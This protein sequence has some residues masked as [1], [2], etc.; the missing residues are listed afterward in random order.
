MPSKDEFFVHPLARGERGARA[1]AGGRGRVRVTQWVIETHFGTWNSAVSAAGLEPHRDNQRLDDAALLGEWGRVVRAVGRVPPRTAYRLA[2]GKYCD[3]LQHRFGGWRGVGRAFAMF[4]GELAEWGDVLAIVERDCSARSE[5]RAPRG[6]ARGSAIERKGVSF[7][8]AD[9]ATLGGPL[10]FEAMRHEPVN[11]QGVVLLFGMLA[12]RL[13]YLIETVQ[14]AFPDCEAKRRVGGGRW[15][16]VRIEFEYESRAYKE[17]G[18]PVERGEACDVLVCW[19]HTWP[20]CPEWIEVLELRPVVERLGARG[21]D[22]I[23]G[24]GA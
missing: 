16:R 22:V 17:H 19:R 15:Q 2:G 7:R 1:R 6:G 11:E 5:R 13:G 10:D 18:H 9:R 21:S 4:A 20:E 24:F 8:L 14:T 23:A 3:V 12:L